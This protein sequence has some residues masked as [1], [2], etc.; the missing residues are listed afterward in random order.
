MVKAGA[1]IDVVNSRGQTPLLLAVRNEDVPLARVLLN[2]GANPNVREPNGA[3]PL[4]IAEDKANLKLVQLL[5][6]WVE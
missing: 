1:D 6:V 5:K 2:N 3:T 4:S